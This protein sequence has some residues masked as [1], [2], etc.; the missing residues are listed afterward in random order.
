MVRQQMPGVQF[1]QQL[2]IRNY[3]DHDS[4]NELAFYTTTLSAI[5][6]VTV[7]TFQQ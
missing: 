2:L 6:I 1:L 4:G 5:Y 7:N 3:I